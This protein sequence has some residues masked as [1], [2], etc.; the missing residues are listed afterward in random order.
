MQYIQ[1]YIYNILLLCDLAL[2][3]I[4]GGSPFETC[5]SRLGR[6][7]DTNKAAH[8]IGNIINWVAY[9]VF[10]QVDHCKLFKQPEEFYKQFEVL[11]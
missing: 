10:N 11:K 5:S 8:F 1:R 6:Y 2:N 3:T 9:K 4:C 7:Y